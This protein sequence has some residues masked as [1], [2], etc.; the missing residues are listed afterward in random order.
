MLRTAINLGVLVTFITGSL[1]VDVEIIKP[2]N[3][4]TGDEV[5]LIFIPNHFIN[6]EQYRKTAQAIQAASELRMWVALTSLTGI[7]DPQNLPD[8]IDEAIEALDNAGM[9]SENFVGV[10]HGKGGKTS[11]C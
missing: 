10:G 7:V 1:A 5:G 8:A 6:G 3:S 9:V 11:N 2:I 4:T